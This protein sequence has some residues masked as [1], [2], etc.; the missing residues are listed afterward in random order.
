VRQA[1]KNSSLRQ[2]PGRRIK[3]IIEGENGS[4]FN[5]NEKKKKNNEGNQTDF[6]WALLRTTVYSPLNFYGNLRFKVTENG[7]KISTHFFSRLDLSVSTVQCVSTPSNV[8]TPETR[9]KCSASMRKLFQLR[10]MTNAN[11]AGD[12]IADRPNA[13]GLRRPLHDRIRSTAFRAGDTGTF[14]EL[15]KGPIIRFLL[16]AE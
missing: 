9:G 8:T 15:G 16:P 1:P 7:K 5:P 11:R 14:E 12:H 3:I 13:C 4:R 2:S 10:R 6:R